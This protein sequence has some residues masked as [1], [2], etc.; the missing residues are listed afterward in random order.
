MTPVPATHWDPINGPTPVFVHQKGKKP[1][2]LVVGTKSGHDKREVLASQVKFKFGPDSEKF[3]IRFVDP[4]AVTNESRSLRSIVKSLL[5]EASKEEKPV[6]GEDSLDSQV[7]RLLS[8]YEA[9]AKHVKTEGRD[10]RSLTR[11]FLIEAEKEADEDAE[12]KDKEEKSEVPKKL[13]SDDIDIKSFVTDVM[14]LID[15]Y[16]SLLEVR[17]TILRRA[18]NYLAKSYEQDVVDGFSAELLDGYG[19]EIGKSAKD[20]E[21]EFEA[22]KAGAAGPMGGSA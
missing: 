20:A 9:E 4:Y 16:D 21:E 1:G 13:S 8:D 3:G 2:T 22:P 10:F 7:D 11:R 12:D 15:N 18:T 5:R 14:R 19:V 17:N 6:D